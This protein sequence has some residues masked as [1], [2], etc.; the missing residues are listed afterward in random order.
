MFVLLIYLLFFLF[1]LTFEI[2]LLS[3]W[4]QFIP[5]VICVTG[6][7]GKSSVTRLIA[8]VLRESG[9]KVLAKTTGSQARYILPDGSEVDFPR[10][11][12]PSVIE[13]K[14]VLKKAFA[15][16]VDCVVTEIMSIKPENHYIEVQK[17]LKPDIIVIT[18]VRCDHIE[19]MGKTKEDIASVISLDI[20]EKA[21]IFIPEKECKSPFISAVKCTGSE[22]IKVNSGV[23][24]YILNLNDNLVKNEF[25]DNIDITYSVCKEIGIEP[26]VIF[27]GISNAQPD[28]GR[29][30]VWRYQYPEAKK[31][32]YFVN[33]FAANDPEST[34]LVVKKVMGILPFTGNK[35]IGL[36]N[37]RED[38]GDR[39]LQW[40]DAVNSGKF[41]FFKKIYVTGR[42]SKVFKRKIKRKEGLII[43]L[44]K[45]TPD[46]ITENIIYNSEA[47]SV[48]FGFGNMGGTGKYIVEYWSKIGTQYEL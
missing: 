14:K 31:I 45:M 11:N 46:K 38:R 6:T 19:E 41:D 26:E 23:S 48:I 15:L 43:T 22:L 47:Q 39:T 33:G 20:K 24:S 5:L 17:I 35:I 30:K 29:L 27:Q 9:R 13:Q 3:K 40:I 12:N 42:H 37:L 25:Q 8:S 36:L 18:N 1:Y 7:R 44:G 10:W 16:K 2:L 32:C 4:R 21:K 28:I 34:Y